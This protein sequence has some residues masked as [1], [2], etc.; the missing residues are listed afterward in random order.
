[1]SYFQGA[2]TYPFKIDGRD[3]DFAVPAVSPLDGWCGQLGAVPKP[4][5]SGRT[6][7]RAHRLRYS[8]PQPQLAPQLH[9]ALA[10]PAGNHGER[11]CNS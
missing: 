2:R 9:E 7:A 8:A 6:L 4:R 5:D 1:M 10:R 3:D 11:L